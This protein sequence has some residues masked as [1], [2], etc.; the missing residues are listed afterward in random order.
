LRARTD[1]ATALNT[2]VLTLAGMSS[3][4]KYDAFGIIPHRSG[5]YTHAADHSPRN[6]PFIDTCNKVPSGGMISA[7][8]GSAA[9]CHRLGKRTVSKFGDDPTHVDFAENG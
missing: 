3:I 8:D 5:P 1:F 2:L 4:R 6:A 7:T 9:L